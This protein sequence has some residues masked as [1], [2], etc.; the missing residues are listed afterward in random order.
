[1]DFKIPLPPPLPLPPAFKEPNANHSLYEIQLANK[2]LEGQ[3]LPALIEL[4][5]RVTDSGGSG[6]GGGSH[7]ALRSATPVTGGFKAKQQQ[8]QQQPPLTYAEFATCGGLLKDPV[9]SCAIQALPACIID[10]RAIRQ[11]KERSTRTMAAA[12]KYEAKLQR[13]DIIRKPGPHALEVTL[14]NIQSQIPTTQAA[15]MQIAQ[16][17][18]THKRLHSAERLW[19][20]G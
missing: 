12:A 18:A 17:V 19:L 7:T 20:R 1:V 3:G 6:G 13:F 11:M 15:N 8:Q 10:T 14:L 2:L 9:I 4:V 5:E 16:H